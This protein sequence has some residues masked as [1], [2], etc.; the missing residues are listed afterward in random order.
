M[1]ALEVVKR[2]LTSIHIGEAC[3]ELHNHKANKKELHE[4]LKRI[5]DLGRP[6]IDHLEREIALLANYKEELNDYSKAVNATVSK[7]GITPHKIMGHLLQIAAT[8]KDVVLPAVNL[9]EPQYWDAARMHRAEAMADKIQAR[10]KDTGVP[11]ALL[12]WGSEL[13]VVLPHEEQSISD[14]LKTARAATEKLKRTAGEVALRMQLEIP[15]NTDEV[16]VLI[17]VAELAAK[18]P[19][20]KGIN[21]TAQDWALRKQDLTELLEAGTRLSAIY[22]EYSEKLMPEAW[23]QNVLEIRQNIRH[24]FSSFNLSKKSTNLC[25]VK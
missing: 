13:Q 9:P 4:E 23:Q 16:A 18:S 1:A 2:R 22:A 24:M 15:E 3:L 11:S 6:A 8:T 7:S 12:F 20:L 19:D 10:L 5:L 21:I 17:E 14:I 25:M